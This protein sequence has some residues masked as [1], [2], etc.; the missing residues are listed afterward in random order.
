MDI[1]QKAEGR[2]ATA[3]PVR[4]VQRARRAEGGRS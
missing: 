3:R 1:Q 2:A 4:V